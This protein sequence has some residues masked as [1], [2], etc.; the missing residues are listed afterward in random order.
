MSELISITIGKQ[1]E[2]VAREY[3]DDEAVKY[4]DRAYTRTW[5]EFNAECDRI[6]K[7]FLALGVRRGDKIAIWATNV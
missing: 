5:G 1:L 6:A 2:K 3:P 7:G 4:T